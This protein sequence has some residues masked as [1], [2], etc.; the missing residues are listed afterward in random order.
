MFHRQTP[1]NT[2]TTS[3]TLLRTR[4]TGIPSRG[5][6]GTFRV[7]RSIVRVQ[8]QATEKRKAG[9]QRPPATENARPNTRTNVRHEKRRRDATKRPRPAEEAGAS[10]TTHQRPQTQRPQRGKPTQSGVLFD[11]QR[12]RN[13]T[14]F[15]TLPRSIARVR[16]VLAGSRDRGCL[17]HWPMTRSAMCRDAVSMIF[18]TSKLEK[19]G[20]RV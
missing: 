8:G 6:A 3:R 5:T 19:Q 15:G 20:A 9:Q 2:L 12:Q 18:R 7:K 11:A 13:R 16:G 10:T 14:E 17:W 1:L 4:P